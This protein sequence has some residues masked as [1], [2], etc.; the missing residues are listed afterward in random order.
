MKAIIIHDNFSTFNL[1]QLNNEL[2]NCH[3]ILYHLKIN[4]GSA[5]ESTLLI[6]GNFT[7]K[8]KL[9]RLKKISNNE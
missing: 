2:K 6:V 3:D 4:Q 1:E 7:R 8:D 5:L 9:K